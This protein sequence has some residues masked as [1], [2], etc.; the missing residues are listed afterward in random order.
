MRSINKWFVWRAT[1]PVNMVDCINEWRYCLKCTIIGKFV[2]YF[3]NMSPFIRKIRRVYRTCGP[4]NKPLERIAHDCETGLILAQ[5]NTSLDFM[6][7][8]AGT[9]A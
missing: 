6:L 5:L 3:K 4:P 2:L 7:L 9:E 8:F 1:R